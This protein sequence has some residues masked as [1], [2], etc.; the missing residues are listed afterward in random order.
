M[1]AYHLAYI[2]LNNRWCTFWIPTQFR[3]AVVREKRVN[4]H[5]LGLSYRIR[6]LITAPVPLTHVPDAE[7]L[8]PCSF[9]PSL[10]SHNSMHFLHAC[11]C[12]LF[13]HFVSVQHFTT[14][15]LMPPWEPARRRTVQRV[16]QRARADP[17]VFHAGGGPQCAHP[18]PPPR[19][20]ASTE[21]RRH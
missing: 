7:L 14:R 21:Q 18:P 17:G 8:P 9:H 5:P 4:T 11:L 19:K 2:H 1:V 13:L 20:R 3:V 15:P 6:V 16:R 12:F 10:L